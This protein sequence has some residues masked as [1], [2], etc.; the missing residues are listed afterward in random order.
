MP[1]P[2]AVC[3]ECDA[4]LSSKTGFAAGQKIRCPRCEAV[5]A[6]PAP[7]SKPVVLDKDDEDEPRPVKKKKKPAVVEVDD[8]DERPRKKKGTKAA[9]GNYASSP[10]RF[11]ILGVL[12]VVMLVMGYFLYRKFT[13]PPPPDV[14]V[15][16]K[17]VPGED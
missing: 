17:P 4:R 3:P 2:Q 7:K 12:V 13:A 8:D 5:F 14:I 10:L 9:E 6:V 1:I 11:V 15:P 16:A